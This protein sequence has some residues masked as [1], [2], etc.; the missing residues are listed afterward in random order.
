M[1]KLLPAL[2]ICILLVTAAF[3]R[4]GRTIGRD[5][6][7]LPVSLGEFLYTVTLSKE[8]PLDEATQEWY[9]E[10]LEPGVNDS[11]FV[12]L[13][14]R[15]F[16]E[17]LVAYQPVYPFRIKMNPA[18]IIAT[19]ETTD[20]VMIED[21]NTFDVQIIAVK[22]R[23]GPEHVVSVT[24]HEEWFYD[25]I[26]FTLTKQVKGIIPNVAY[27][28]SFDGV[29]EIRPT[30]YIPVTEQA[31]QKT[32]VVVP[33]ITSDFHSD[34]LEHLNQYYRS[35]IVWD[36][37]IN[38]Q[39]SRA[40]QKILGDMRTRAAGKKVVMYEP[41]F[42]FR[43][44]VSKAAVPQAIN[45][46]NASNGL[47][48]YED[49]EVDLRSGIFRKKVKGI[50]PQ[51]KPGD[52][53]GNVPQVYT[54]SVLLPFNN[55]QPG[56]VSGPA[57]IDR[58][59]YEFIYRPHDE[60]WLPV[61]SSADSLHFI[62]MAENI[63][64]RVK[65]GEL[66]VF[67]ASSGMHW[68]SPWMSDY[69][70][71]DSTQVNDLFYITDTVYVEDYMDYHKEVRHYEVGEIGNCGLQCYESWQLDPAK[72]TMQKQMLYVGIKGLDQSGYY[73]ETN[74]LE[75]R[76]FYFNRATPLDSIRQQKYLLATHV[77]TPVLLNWNEYNYSEKVEGVPTVTYVDNATENIDPSKRYAMIQPVI[78]QILAGKTVAYADTS[79]KNVFTPATFRAMLD[80]ARSQS[81]MNVRPGME[82]A[83]FNQLYFVEDWYYNP[84]TGQ[85]HKEV[86][87]ITF[88]HRGNRIYNQET[89]T[90]G[91][92]SREYFT[93][94]MNPPK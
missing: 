94:R 19:V 14:E 89:E 93:V 65:R 48:F 40:E 91:E 57:T 27:S 7:P 29:T 11:I 69:S 68:Y 61:M 56:S 70:R 73:R 2:T 72:M 86:V 71:L 66:A 17:E 49:W 52:G 84:A 4:G 50:I 76:Y 24:F 25:A 47:L 44:P 35:G 55:Y 45:K 13:F 23:R 5:P 9:H 46:V 39:Q 36:S 31:E 15:I 81:K 74:T 28:N 82:Y 3:T 85:L 18:E 87:A 22:D 33:G 20:S 79:M 43:T 54:K 88:G 80:S 21:P 53:E 10:Y 6:K 30:V 78:E 26:T 12:P 75:H 77:R 67:G 32:N 60:K 63:D 16:K 64:A 1:K 83:L 34:G 62:A 92:F 58:I 38:V 90:S 51:A 8:K 59:D 37:A 42:P 41:Q